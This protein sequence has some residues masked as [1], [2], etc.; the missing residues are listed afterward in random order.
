[1]PTS[2]TRI[3]SP[4]ELYAFPNLF[5][6]TITQSLMNWRISGISNGPGSNTD[7]AEFFSIVNMVPLHAN[8]IITLTSARYDWPAA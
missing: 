2:K 6:L 7:L 5:A 3:I 8:F 4:D 1:M